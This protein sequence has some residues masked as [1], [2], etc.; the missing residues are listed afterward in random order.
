MK[1]QGLKQA[2]EKAQESSGGGGDFNEGVHKLKVIRASHGE[3]TGTLSWADFMINLE[4]TTEGIPFDLKYSCM[5]AQ[6]KGKRKGTIWKLAALLQAL[7][8]TVSD[9]GEFD[10]KE[11]EGKTFKC[12]VYREAKGY[13]RCHE[14]AF[15]TSDSDSYIKSRFNKDK[16]G[17]YVR[18]LEPIVDETSTV[19]SGDDSAPPF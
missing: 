2:T 9:D 14:M 19:M 15:K 7:G 11:A 4:C 18:G 17:G 3:C 10:V 16:A 12:F 5:G 6:P 8:V 13:A 1:V